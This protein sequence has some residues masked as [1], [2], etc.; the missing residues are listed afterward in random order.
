MRLGFFLRPHA[1]V[2]TSMTA[3]CID[4]AGLSRTKRFLRYTD[5]VAQ[6]VHVLHSRRTRSVIW[7][8]PMLCVCFETSLSL[9][10][11]EALQ[12]RDR[13]VLLIVQVL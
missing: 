5:S 10:W 12:M 13:C 3:L 6:F 9:S 7:S 11:R 8:T 2:C 1:R 4:E